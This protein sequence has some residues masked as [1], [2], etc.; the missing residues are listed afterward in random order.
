MFFAMDA[1]QIA[2]KLVVLVLALALAVGAAPMAMAG[3]AT[4]G[5]DMGS[6]DMQA[7]MSQDQHGVPLQKQ[8][9]PAK[10][11]DSCCTATCAG[12]VGF[13]QVAYSPMLASNPAVPGWSVQAGLASNRSR[14]EL[15]PPIAIL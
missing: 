8:Q 6:M 15:P 10:D 4:I 7:S 3:T 9:T 14:P 2:L 13:P 12:T 1:N 5:C 11:T